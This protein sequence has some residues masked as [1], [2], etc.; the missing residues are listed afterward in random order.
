NIFVTALDVHGEPIDVAEDLTVRLAATLGSVTPPFII[1]RKGTSTCTEEIRLTATMPGTERVYAY[2]PRVAR[3]FEKEIEYERPRPSRLLVHAAPSTVANSGRTPVDI[4]VILQDDHHNP[5]ASSDRALTV[6]MTSTL[7]TLSRH[8]AIILKGTAA[9]GPIVLRSARAGS[10]EVTARA[11][12]LPDASVSVS[13]E[14]PW[15]L[16]FIAVE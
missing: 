16:V 4:M 13:F 11:E 9:A 15:L 6:V 3:G 12:G 8:E 7:G 2:S 1:I 10:A 5:A 14:F